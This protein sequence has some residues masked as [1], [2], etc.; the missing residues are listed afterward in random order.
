[1]DLDGA[2]VDKELK[3]FFLIEQQ[4]AQFQQKVSFASIDISI[5]PL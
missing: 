3:E 5:Q 2:N 4:K 1:M